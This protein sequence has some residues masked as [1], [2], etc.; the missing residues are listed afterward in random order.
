M[1][2]M[3]NQKTCS[4][5]IKNVIKEIMG[6]TAEIMFIGAMVIATRQTNDAVNVHANKFIS[7]FNKRKGSKIGF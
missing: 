1:H 4:T 3:L 6:T 7:K 5:K 2:Y